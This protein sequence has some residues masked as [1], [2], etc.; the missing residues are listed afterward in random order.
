MMVVVGVRSTNKNNY[1]IDGKEG[2]EMVIFD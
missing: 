1:K 2:S